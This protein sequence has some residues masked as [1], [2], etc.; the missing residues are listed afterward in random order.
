MIIEIISTGD[1]VLTGFVVDTNSAWLCQRLL[2][3]GWQVRRRQTVGDRM[4]DLVSV[5]KER[6]QIAD[7]I[8]VNGGLGPTSDDKTTEAAALAAGVE[9]ELRSEWLE[10]LKDR[11]AARDRIMPHS[12]SKQAMLPAGAQIIPNPIGTAC[13]FVMTIGQARCYF[14]PGVPSEFKRMVNEQILPDLGYQGQKGNTEVRRYFTF[15][16][17][18]SS[19]SDRLDTLSWPTHIEL[20][21]RS[22]MPIIEIKLISQQAD[23]TDFTSAEAQLLDVITPYLVARQELNLP[24]ELSE[25]LASRPL[26]IYEQGT[27]G[28][29]LSTLAKEIPELTGSIESLPATADNLLARIQEEKQLTLAI[30]SETEQGISIALWDGEKGASQTLR[31]SIQNPGLR[32]GIIAF[33]AQ[34]MLRRYLN[35]EPVLGSYETL[36]RTNEVVAL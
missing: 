1:E 2:D 11:Y 32:H 33:A 6:G 21:Y 19:L 30:G 12:N 16:V 10:L 5:L 3:H 18:E 31:V 25:K 23:Q 29:V 17:S 7:V 20:G 28:I 4:D 27:A 14:T 36:Q 26:K 35:N 8:L 34:D 9:L 15:G 13:G 22:S 24:A